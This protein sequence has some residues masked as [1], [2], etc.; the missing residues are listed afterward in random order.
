MIP[1]LFAYKKYGI[2]YF[3]NAIF[4]KMVLVFTILYNATHIFNDLIKYNFTS[5]PGLLFD[6]FF[7]VLIVLSIITFVKYIMTKYEISLS[8]VFLK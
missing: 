6:M 2:K 8:Q 3:A 7:Y 4:L 1:V 5:I